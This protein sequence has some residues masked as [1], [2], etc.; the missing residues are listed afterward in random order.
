MK[1]IHFFAALL[2]TAIGSWAFYPKAAAPSGYMMVV[3]RF[4]VT[5]GGA[6][7]S[8]SVITPDGQIQTQEINAQRGS[9]NKLIEANDQ[10]HA[11]E[12][13]KINELQQA[14][15]RVINSTQITNEAGLINETTFL[16]EKQ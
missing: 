16:L 12:L 8:V 3:S 14:G 7:N 9:V 2:L 1:K 11:S 13:K 4:S 15:W 10:R 5:F 6:K